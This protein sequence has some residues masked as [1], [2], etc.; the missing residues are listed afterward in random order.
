MPEEAAKHGI[1]IDLGAGLTP[2]DRAAMKVVTIFPSLMLLSLGDTINWMRW[3]PTAVD[4]TDARAGLLMPK[5]A[6]AVV[7]DSPELR[8]GMQAGLERV[9]AE[10]EGAMARVRRAATS[11]F[12][13]RGPLSTKEGVLVGL[14]RYLARALR[15]AG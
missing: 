2:A 3:I 9:N 13:G 14:Y 15:D 1:G 10:D 11:A 4:R 8:A 12:A 6:L 5:A 7:G